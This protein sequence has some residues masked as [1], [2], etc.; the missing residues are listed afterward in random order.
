M[1]DTM[2]ETKS[3]AFAFM[4]SSHALVF[5]RLVW[6][7][8]APRVRLLR[9]NVEPGAPLISGAW[10][11]VTVQTCGEGLGAQRAGWSAA[12][13]AGYDAGSQVG[14]AAGRCEL[15]GCAVR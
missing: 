8:P 13:Y 1:S 10:L 9:A 11:R 12:G 5:S 6:R 3:T 14:C 7:P 2:Y 15:R 4:R